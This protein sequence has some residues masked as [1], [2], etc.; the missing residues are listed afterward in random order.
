MAA[1]RRPIPEEASEELL[2]QALMNASEGTFS[3]DWL[4]K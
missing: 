4:A 1:A 3:M 2:N